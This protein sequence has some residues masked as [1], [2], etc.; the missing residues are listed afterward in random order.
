MSQKVKMSSSKLANYFSVKKLP[1]IILITSLLV[2]IVFF[3]AFQFIVKGEPYLFASEYIKSNKIVS[4]RLGVIKD[5]SVSLFS[6]LS[7]RGTKKGYANY[8][9]FVKGVDG[10]GMIYINME[11]N[12]GKWQIRRASLVLPD[13]TQINITSR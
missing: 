2:V 3:L 8:K 10:N 5:M 9:I 11:K 13:R 4:E 7:Y 12:A 6:S 1:K